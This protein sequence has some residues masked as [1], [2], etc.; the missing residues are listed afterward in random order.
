MAGKSSFVLDEELNLTCPYGS[1]ETNIT[2]NN[3]DESTIRITVSSEQIENK[4]EQGKYLEKIAILLS[5]ILGF[6]EENPY[7]G[8]PFITLNLNTFHSKVEG[9][10]SGSTL[11]LSGSL[12][13]ESTTH[14]KFSDLDFTSIQDTDLLNH[15]YNGLKAEG[16]KS[17]FFHLFLILEILE[18]CELYKRTFPDGTLFTEK[19]KGEIREFSKK[20]SGAQKSS[21]LNCL[22]RTEK[23]R[24]EK[25]LHLIKQLDITEIKNVTGQHTVEQATIKNIIDA[26]NKLFHK[27]ESF[28]NELLY[29]LWPP[30]S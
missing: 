24:N 3:S 4:E 1:E 25:L 9:P 6:K 17:K 18:G 8:T 27:S 10:S 19:E 11:Q 7:Y 13:I 12:C 21:L 23:F 14:V 15:Y 22:S 30:K 16:E 28:D 26:R 29:F 5:S 2:V 20:F